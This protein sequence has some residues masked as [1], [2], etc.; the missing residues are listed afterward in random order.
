MSVNIFQ[1]LL[2]YD[3]SNLVHANKSIDLTEKPAS[4]YV[5]SCVDQVKSA[6][7][8]I[9]LHLKQLQTIHIYKNTMRRAVLS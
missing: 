4:W 3:R 5:M 1:S 7:V 6:F 9:V 8:M 2:G